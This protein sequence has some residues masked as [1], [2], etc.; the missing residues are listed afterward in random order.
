MRVKMI[1]LLL[2]C[3]LALVAT[4]G[5]YPTAQS[6]VIQEADGYSPIPTAAVLPDKALL[7]RAIFDATHAADKPAQ[8]LPALNMAGSELNALKV[9]G[10]PLTNAKF[11]IVFHGDAID[12]ILKNEQYKKKFGVSNP[13]LPVL[14]KLKKAGVELFVCGQNLAFANIGLAT[15]SPDVTLASDALIV[16]ITYQNKGYAVMNF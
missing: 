5:E 12:G 8:I 14:S 10:V 3:S 4:A 9:A 6:P 15:L 2:F 11:V 1:F 7:Y 16:L 13:N